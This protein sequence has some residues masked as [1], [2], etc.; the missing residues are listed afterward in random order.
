M[1]NQNTTKP[2]RAFQGRIRDLMQGQEPFPFLTESMVRVPTSVVNH[3]DYLRRGGKVSVHLF[4]RAFESLEAGNIHPLP[5]KRRLAFFYA[6][7]HA[8]TQEIMKFVAGLPGRPT[9]LGP[10]GLAIA[11]RYCS[12][13]MPSC[14][15]LVSLQSGDE[16]KEGVLAAGR[17]IDGTWAI[18]VHSGYWTPGT[19]IMV[20][21]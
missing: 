16:K 11:I 9:L 10:Q 17:C 13:V 4:G 15:T 14:K 12:N 1:L 2:Y 18:N 21:F 20:S 5:G 8:T 19:I 7:K 6:T 3:F